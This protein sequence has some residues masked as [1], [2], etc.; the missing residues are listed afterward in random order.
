M[1]TIEFVSKTILAVLTVAAAL[2]VS[3]YVVDIEA[4]VT[5]LEERSSVTIL[6]PLP[7]EVIIDR[8]KRGDEP[9]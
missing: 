2:Y 9:K 5:A 7:I 4:R 8:S 3:S 6:P 1:S